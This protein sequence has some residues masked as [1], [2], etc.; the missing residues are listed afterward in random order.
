MLPANAID[1]YPNL[2]TVNTQ[3]NTLITTEIIICDIYKNDI[4]LR[5]FEIEG[6]TYLLFGSYYNQMLQYFEQE[7]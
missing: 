1:W 5:F 4:I 2:S 6:K 3:I 7:L